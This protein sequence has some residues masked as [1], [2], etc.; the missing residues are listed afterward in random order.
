M[1][2]RR[3]SDKRSIRLT[4]DEVVVLFE[5]LHRWEDDGTTDRLPYVHAAEKVAL[6]RLAAALTYRVDEA[7][8][9]NYSDVVA[10]AREA[11]ATLGGEPLGS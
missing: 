10:K 9:P 7:F 4:H 11:L 6:W 8:S 2:R 5:L 3:P 1:L